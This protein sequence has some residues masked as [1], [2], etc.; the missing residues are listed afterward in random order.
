MDSD[1]T[2]PSDLSELYQFAYRTFNGKVDAVIN[3]FGV[4]AQ[5]RDY[6]WKTSLEDI[7]Q[8]VAVNLKGMLL[9]NKYGISAF[10]ENV[11]SRG[12]LNKLHVE[13]SM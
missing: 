1:V 12:M 7:D 4:S 11:C 5:K 13:F 10:V 6:L 9:S 3:N 2:E 8:I